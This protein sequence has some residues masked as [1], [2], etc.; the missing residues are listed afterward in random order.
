[1][2]SIF[3]YFSFSVIVLCISGSESGIFMSLPNS[4]YAKIHFQNLL[5]KLKS[6]PFISSEDIQIEHD[7]EVTREHQLIPTKLFNKDTALNSN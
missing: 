4:V 3:Y 2:L 1:M 6:D 5:P 7:I